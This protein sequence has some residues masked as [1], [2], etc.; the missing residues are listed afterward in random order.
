VNQP[1]ATDKASKWQQA[2]APP[3]WSNW[4]LVLVGIGATIAALCTLGAIR[5][6]AR[7]MR[8]QTTH[9][10]N[11]VIQARKAANAAKRSADAYEETVRLT[12]RAD[13]LMNSASIS[14]PEED[15]FWADACVVIQF[16]NFGR[17]RA[18]N[19]RISAS[20][21]I[22]ELPPSSPEQMPVTILA[23]GDIDRLRFNTFGEWLTRQSMQDILDGRLELR[24]DAKVTYI[25]IFGL[26][27]TTENGGIYMPRDRVFRLE[28]GR[29]D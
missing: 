5:R 23:P 4:A 12:E 19:V 29:A 9:L 18:N 15:P 26:P 1:A 11:S 14:K 24:F 13:V 28:Y 17:T 27:H 3:T 22:P 8:Y 6:Q 20:L 10:K 16:R 2:T 25:D 7:S 21:T